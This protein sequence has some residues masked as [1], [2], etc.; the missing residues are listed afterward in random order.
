LPIT[1]KGVI[2]Y[3]KMSE[4]HGSRATARKGVEF[5]AVQSQDVQVY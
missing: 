2:S 1:L 4:L 3:A 5:W